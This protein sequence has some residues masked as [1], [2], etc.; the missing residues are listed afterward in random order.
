MSSPSP[1]LLDPHVLLRL[2]RALPTFFH[3]RAEGF[4]LFADDLP[5]LYAFNLLLFSGA[6]RH[7][8]RF[9]VVGIFGFRFLVFGI[10]V[11]TVFFSALSGDE[12]EESGDESFFEVGEAETVGDGGDGGSEGGGKEMEGFLESL[13]LWGGGLVGWMWCGLVF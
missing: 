8:E 11:H 13:D 3:L 12:D 6:E 5:Q 9:I 7:W 1:S 2:L 4:D 10:D